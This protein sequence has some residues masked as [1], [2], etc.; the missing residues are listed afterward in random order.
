M[1][2]TARAQSMLAA[3][4]RECER[5]ARAHYENFPVASRV[6]PPRMRP[7]IAAV[8]AF[9]RTAD[10]VADEGARPSHERQRLLDDWLRR[11]HAAGAGAADEH[12]AIFLAL[13]DTMRRFAIPISLFEDLISAFRQDT[14]TVRYARWDDVLDYCRRSANPVGRIVLRI[15]GY[16]N[17]R[18]DQSSDALCSALQLTNFWQDLASDWQRG[19]LYIPAEVYEAAGASP[20]DLDAQTM[21]PA[22]R[23][24]LNHVAARTRELFKAGRLVC[25]GV[26]GRLRAELRLTWAGGSRIL[27]R[28][29][30]G[31][32]DPFTHRPM[33][34][35]RD[36]PGL[37]RDASLFRT[38]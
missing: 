22:W 19:R 34:G 18:F 30:S 23:D 16:E 27:D 11:L 10:D 33:I 14:M 25:D 5:I 28:V 2:S 12:D 35:L 29:Q 32:F 15:A 3:A 26:R 17:P 20:S 7:H 36:V 6:L 8:Y 38:S 24:A 1:T 9:A 37:L 4:Y 13:G 31:D 21:T